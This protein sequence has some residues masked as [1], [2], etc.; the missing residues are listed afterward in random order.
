MKILKYLLSLAIILG[1]IHN[2]FGFKL[3]NIA[4]FDI[5]SDMDA[6]AKNGLKEMHI[7]DTCLRYLISDGMIDS[8]MF[9]AGGRVVLP[10]ENISESKRDYSD[11]RRIIGNGTSI[12]D[13]LSSCMKLLPNAGRIVVISNGREVES[14]ISSATLSKLM[15]SKGF[16]IDAIV[17]SAGCDSV[18]DES[19]YNS[20]D[21]TLYERNRVN[22]GLKHIVNRTGGEII[23]IEGISN[24]REKIDGLSSVVAKGKPN[25]SKKSC[26]LNVDLTKKVLDRIKPQKLYI[27]EVDTN[28]VITH[29]G[30]KYHGLNNILNLANSD[31]FILI[32]QD[33]TSN[34]GA[35]H[36]FNVIFVSNQNELDRK[37]SILNQM[38][39]GYFD[40]KLSQDTPID[41]LPMLYYN[42]A[43]GKMLLCGLDFEEPD[44]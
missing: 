1:S 34:S 11:L 18:Y 42:G 16:R 37:R 23:T 12:N 10:V 41:A 26:N 7:A 19:W 38:S 17:V 9:F 32:N 8:V 44:E 28:V 27:C 40:S 14:S 31:P 2:V 33:L 6:Y 22:S 24:I 29:H 39:S 35:S 30:I 3:W 15:Q 20:T 4:L 5:S 36:P 25:H 13:A 43:G 21:S